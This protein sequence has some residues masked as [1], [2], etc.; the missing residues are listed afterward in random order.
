MHSSGRGAFFTKVNRPVR[1]IACREYPNRSMAAKAEVLIKKCDHDFKLAW[2][3]A[4]PVPE[5][6]QIATLDI[7]RQSSRPKARSSPV[8][9]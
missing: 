5:D 7:V 3:D 6:V 4:N 2:A 9:V 1:F 8:I